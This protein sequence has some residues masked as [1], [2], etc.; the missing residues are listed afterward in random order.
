[1]SV[2]EGT[3]NGLPC[4]TLSHSSGATAL[5]FV[6]AAHLASWKTS[7]GEEQL[8]MSSGTEY[9]GGKAMRGGVPVCW[10]QFADRGAYGKHGFARNSDKWYI[11]RTSTE[12]FP[13][14]VLGLDDDEATRAAWPFPFQLRYSVT[15][16]GP[17]QVSVSMTVLNSGDAPMEFTTAL[18]T[19]FRVPKVGAITLQGLQVTR[20][21]VSS[22]PR[23]ARLQPLGRPTAALTLPRSP[24]AAGVRAATC[25]ASL[26]PSPGSPSRSPRTPHPHPSPSP[27]AGRR[28][29]S[30]A[31]HSPL[32]P[33]CHSWARQGLTYEDSVKARDKFT[34]EE[35]NLPIVGEVRCAC[36]SAL[37]PTRNARAP[38]Q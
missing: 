22:A 5:V 15:L 36:A 11:V 3:Q 31:T 8:F 20:E 30:R 21:A 23:L 38:Q 19:Y 13:C 34:Q 33:L 37:T 27:C 17:D 6:Y 4:V 29:A 18:H 25:K 24:T 32:P 9:G 26:Q 12:P 2:T 14:V 10:P 7:D 16:D 28:N 35:E 1:M